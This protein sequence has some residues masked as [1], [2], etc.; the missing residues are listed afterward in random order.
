MERVILHSDLDNFYASVECLEQP[1]LQ[2]KPVAV[3]GDPAS[4]RGIVLAKNQQAKQLGVKTGEAIWQ[5]RQKCPDLVTVPPRHEVYHEYSERVFALYCRYT[6]RVEPFGPD[7]AWMDVT[8]CGRL[9]GTGEEIAEKIRTAIRQEIGLTVSIGVSFNKTCAKLASDLKKPNAVCAIPRPRYREIVWPM[10]V[11]NLLFVGRRTRTGLMRY[12]LNTVGSVAQADL[13][14]LRSVFGK[15][16]ERLYEYANGIEHDPVQY[17]DARAPV[18]SIGN[19]VTLPQDISEEEEV[20]RVLFW[21][22]DHVSGRMRKE[23]LQG[24]TVCLSVKTAEF[25]TY[26]R[27]CSLAS[28]CAAA[29]PMMQA[30]MRLFRESRS[31]GLRIRSLGVRVT[32]LQAEHAEQLTFFPEDIKNHKHEQIAKITDEIKLRFGKDAITRALLLS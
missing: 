23:H 8:G 15:S 22:C 4:R 24:K 31:P 30:V 20:K 25:I 19:S 1:E 7:E 3:C 16:G 10:P 2:G 13:G 9:F 18:K 29:E 12:G 17:W 14:F 11:G 21:L 27:Q 26:D 6:D 32:N 28:P 5:A